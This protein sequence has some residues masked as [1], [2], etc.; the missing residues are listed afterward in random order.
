MRVIKGFK[1]LRQTGDT[2]VEVLLVLTIIGLVLGSATA[3][4]SRSTSNL[5]QTQ[6][7]AVADRIARGQLE[8]LKTYV[9]T[10][11]DKDIAT[12]G[13]LMTP[14]FCMAAQNG[15]ANDPRVPKS[16]PDTCAT[17]QVE[18]GASY[19]TAINVTQVSGSPGVFD[20]HVKVTWAGITVK[21]GNIDVYYRIYNITG[22]GVALQ[23]GQLCQAGYRHRDGATGP[24]VPIDPSIRAVTRAVTPDKDSSGGLVEPNC[25]K[26]DY[27]P[28]N[29]ISIRLSEIGAGAGPSKTAQT[30]QDFNGLSS[31]VLF[32]PLKKSGTYRVEM[33]G[34]P[35]N[36]ITC[37]TSQSGALKVEEGQ[38]EVFNFTAKPRIPKQATLNTYGRSFPTWHLYNNGGDR[39]YQDFIF[40]NP[41]SSTT[42]LT[43]INATLSN[44]TDFK[45]YYVNTCYGSLEPGA[46]CTVRVYFWPPAGSAAY[47]YLG[48]AGIKTGT[49]TLTN[50]NGVTPTYANLQG[51]TVSNMMRP[52]DYT[53]TPESDLLRSY[54]VECYNNADACGYYRIYLAGNGNL[55]LMNNYCAYRGDPEYNGSNASIH[56][57]ASDSN[58]VY[59]GTDVARWASGT[60]GNSNLWAVVGNSGYAYLT[61]GYDGGI[62]KWL[63]ANA[64]GSIGCSPRDP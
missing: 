55:Y 35:S 50:S 61:Q 48:N 12:V 37:G 8:Y 22:A 3:M 64:D 4:S 38:E 32:S 60:A 44:T 36:Y 53:T 7:S 62:V 23:T 15:Q 5:Q 57:Q 21:T 30:T 25:N 14:G 2:I 18:G 42:A 26:A 6:E 49:I 20:V 13:S 63:N 27:R 45:N 1:R 58:F 52:G 39:Y 31:S 17:T 47:N 24:C 33:L 16:G 9:R 40:T 10:L 11:K 51:K 29:N 59:Y 19:T 56:M 28:L 54:H 41:A 34:V 43:G 46:S